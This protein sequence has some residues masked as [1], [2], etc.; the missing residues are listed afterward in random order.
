MEVVMK[1]KSL[2]ILVVLLS[3]SALLHAS[4]ITWSGAGSDDRWLTAGNW[5]TGV[6]PTSADRVYLD[7]PGGLILVE[8][9]DT[10]LCNKILGPCRTT[11]AVTTFR[12]TGG[13]LNNPSY[14]YVGQVSGGE[15]IIDMQG[16][17]LTTRDLFIGRTSG[18]GNVYISGGTMNVT[19]TTSGTGLHIPGD[20]TGTGNMYVTGGTL[21]CGYLGMADYGL[22][23]IGTNGLVRVSGDVRS[24]MAIYDAN[25][26]ITADGG[27]AD[28]VILYDGTYTTLQSSSNPA[29]AKANTPS[30]LNASTGVAT[31]GT[32]L[33]WAAGT[34]ATAHNV[35]LGTDSNTLSLVSSAQSGTTYNAGNLGYALK[36]YWRIDEVTSGGTIAGNVWSF[37]TKGSITLDYF[38]T[39]AD[40]AALKAVWKDGSAD[41]SSGSSIALSTTNRE[42]GGV[43]SCA[44]SYNNTGSVGGKY[45]SEIERPVPFANYLVNNAKS[46]DIWYRG[47]TGNSVQ[48]MYVGLTDG[49]NTA[50]VDVNSIASQESSVWICKHI[51]LAAFTAANP[52][53]NLNNLTK[54]YI[55]VGSKT[56]TTSGGSG[57]VYIDYM[58]LWPSRC[59]TTYKSDLNGDCKVDFADFAQ[60]ATDWLGNGMWPLW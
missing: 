13:T 33:S 45:Y 48:K 7:E 41:N 54:M 3:V 20:S 59:L 2:L 10:V 53:L 28:V 26:Y 39:Y 51:D 43:Y 38:E 31:I 16:G 9:G 29:L 12:M 60:V 5:A 17:T 46:M 49:T 4:D 32:V 8:T 11:A 30:P 35:Y 50:Y 57:L 22:L 19:G 52:S 34:S 25:G 18:Y 55:G 47:A 42:T 27:T 56:A 14:W 23:D 36:Y 6:A 40:T 15:G 44:L 21:T 58:G 24:T 1:L 37:T